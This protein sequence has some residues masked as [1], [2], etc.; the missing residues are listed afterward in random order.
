MLIGI[1]LYIL[2]LFIHFHTYEYGWDSENE[3]RVKFPLWL[4]IIFFL[5]MLIPV[6]NIIIFISGTLLY[7]CEMFVEDRICFKIVPKN[8]V[9]LKIINFLNKKY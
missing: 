7:F 1:G 3:E 6:I 5:L 9:V 4:F 2:T 8:P